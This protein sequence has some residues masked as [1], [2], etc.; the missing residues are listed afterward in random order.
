M[1]KFWSWTG[2]DTNTSQVE[3]FQGSRH[4]FLLIHFSRRGLDTKL[5]FEC[6]QSFAR[7]FERY[8]LS[9][10]TII[11]PCWSSLRLCNISKLAEVGLNNFAREI[12]FE[13]FLVKS[14]IRFDNYSIL[15]PLVF[16]RCLDQLNVD[17]T[18]DLINLG[19]GDWSKFSMKT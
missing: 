3:S 15:I 10:P 9:E 6:N 18:F 2:S 14:S 16:S 7:G 19:F 5:E 11:G 8:I 13:D 4:L 17:W 12:K 1:Y